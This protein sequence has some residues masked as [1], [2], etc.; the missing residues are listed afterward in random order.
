VGTEK[1]E[2][3]EELPMT[4]T[5]PTVVKDHEFALD[6]DVADGW[7]STESGRFFEVERWLCSC[8]DRGDW[9]P[10]SETTAYHAWLAH[11]RPDHGPLTDDLDEMTY[12][13]LE[14]VIH[15]AELAEDLPSLSRATAAELKFRVLQRG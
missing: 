6:T 7:H 11:V 15:L 1:T 14:R 5:P 4:E 9:Q 8:G 12:S 3:T 2:R 13:E 10:S